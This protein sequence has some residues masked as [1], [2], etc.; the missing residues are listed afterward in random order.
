MM[1]GF[2]PN[3]NLKACRNKAIRLGFAR[4]RQEISTDFPI[5][6]SNDVI[7]CAFD[8]V[9]KNSE[10][11]VAGWIWPELWQ[12]VFLKHRNRVSES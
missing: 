10:A 2:I 5:D 3:S 11:M 4:G 9:Y 12:V 1:T 7:L 8:R 6:P